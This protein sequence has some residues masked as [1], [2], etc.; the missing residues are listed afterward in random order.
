VS[1]TSYKCCNA[2]GMEHFTAVSH[3]VKVNVVR[4]SSTDGKIYG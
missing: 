4:L 1:Y 2:N 3:T